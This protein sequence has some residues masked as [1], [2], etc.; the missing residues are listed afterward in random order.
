[1]MLK[2]GTMVS[3]RDNPSMKGILQSINGDECSVFIDNQRQLFPSSQL[4]NA[5]QYDPI[6]DFDSVLSSQGYGGKI[7]MNRILVNEKIS[8]ALS[9][10]FYSMHYGN[11]IFYPHQYKPVLQFVENEENSLIIAD[12]VGLG[13]TIEAMFIWQELQVRENARSLLIL[14]PSLLENKW[15]MELHD[16]FGIEAVIVDK[17]GLLDVM[18]KSKKRSALIFSF[19]KL[20][21]VKE[22]DSFLAYLESRP[23]IGALFDLIIIDEAHYL[24]NEKTRTNKNARK[25]IGVSKA[26]VM[27]TATPVQTS[28]RNL[29]NLLHLIDT[30]NVPSFNSFETIISDNT[31][32][33]K[34]MTF[35]QTPINSTSEE[36]RKN[37]ERCLI[38][39]K[40]RNVLDARTCADAEA[41]L[42]TNADDQTRLAFSYRLEKSM[43]LSRYMSRSRKKMVLE[44]QVIRDAKTVRITLT[45][46][47]KE[48]YMKASEILNIHA[49]DD[50]GRQY[51]ANVVRKRLI[52]SCLPVGIERMCEKLDA[53]YLDMFGML[54]DDEEISQVPDELALSA[55]SKQDIIQQARRLGNRDSKYQGLLRAL[56]EASNAFPVTE[57]KKIIIFTQFKMVGDYLDEK[58]SKEKFTVFYIH[59]KMNNLEKSSTIEAFRECTRLA[60]L[61]STEVGSEGIDLQFCNTMVNYDLPWNP[62]RIEQRIGRLDRIGQKSKKISIY[63]LYCT[64]TMEDRVLEK[65]HNRIDNFKSVIGE[66]GEILGVEIEKLVIDLSSKD[67]SEKELDEVMENNEFVKKVNE[68]M[69]DKL[70]SCG[71]LMSNC[72]KQELENIKRAES[73]EHYVTKLDL[74]NYVINYLES[75][76][77]QE[78]SCIPRKD[79]DNCYDLTL[80]FAVKIGLEQYCKKNDVDTRLCDLERRTQLVCFQQNEKESIVRGAEIIDISH[81]LIRWVAEQVSSFSDVP[82]DICISHLQGEIVNDN[83]IKDLGKGLAY[84]Y[85]EKWTA[86]GSVEKNELHFKAGI[87]S[88]D[89]QWRLL[90]D[91]DSERL[92]VLASNKGYSDEEY[93]TYYD[94]KYTKELLEGQIKTEMDSS[95][96]QFTSS[97]IDSEDGLR[98]R[99]LN[100]QQ[101]EHDRAVDGYKETIQKY[102]DM[103]K[104][105]SSIA[106]QRKADSII[107]MNK[108]H[109]SKADEKLKYDMFRLQTKKVSTSHIPLLSGLICIT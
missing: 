44:N 18:Q 56:N 77:H 6:N 58:L 51:L 98:S 52:S 103:M 95:F 73:L 3:V 102:E 88:E 4:E 93:M 45:P 43:Y 107:R 63:N 83:G 71:S 33:L 25:L 57:N 89:W 9:N 68:A 41:L 105:D 91:D 61:L 31:E 34:L 48:I 17:T 86:K 20:K 85:V 38:G 87:I 100:T 16:R 74:Y 109:I 11:T 106:F 15:Q 49:E 39:I 101:K 67:L 94:E 35:F 78:F 36:Q 54:V 76:Y 72:G 21:I 7:E 97:F 37:A 46:E 59:G 79:N 104:G 92:V 8:G 66:I 30:Q 23:D 5:H 22:N 53:Y 19:A 70:E 62:M 75:S 96:K 26:T 65:L 99:R 2:I 13:K 84:Y 40:N 80:P 50:G 55:D 24:R 27:L 108:G 81:P 64:D 60:I 14:C 47:E 90:D 12:E 29:Y 69:N 28:D 82:C 10:I 32:Q 1:M 42:Q